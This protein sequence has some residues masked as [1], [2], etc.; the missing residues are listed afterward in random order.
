MFY[1]L[2]LSKQLR[3]RGFWTIQCKLHIAPNIVCKGMLLLTVLHCTIVKYCMF[4]SHFCVMVT[5]AQILRRNV[6]T[7]ILIFFP[8][9]RRT[10]FIDKAKVRLKRFF[11]ITF[12]P[13][14]FNSILAF[15]D[16][17][18]DFYN[19]ILAFYNS[20]LAFFNSILAFYNSI[21]AFYYSILDFYNSILAFYNSILPFYNSILDFYNSI[22]DFYNSK[23][24][25]FNSKLDTVKKEFLV[26]KGASWGLCP[27]GAKAFLLVTDNGRSRLDSTFCVI[28]QHRK[29]EFGHHRQSKKISNAQELTVHLS[30]TLSSAIAQIK[31]SNSL[32]TNHAKKILPQR[33]PPF[34]NFCRLF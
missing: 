11:F 4:P 5:L 13:R 2:V 3:E 25:F 22:L 12:Y 18:L 14:F 24:T 21:L 28:T 34:F 15:H 6:T 8:F 20:I 23:L 26:L 10:S 1:E 9:F 27:P 31:V 33:P 7:Y 30:K 16:S 32:I 29:F 19:S 17:I